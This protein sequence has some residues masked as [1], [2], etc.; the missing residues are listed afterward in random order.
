MPRPMGKLPSCDVGSIAVLLH[1]PFEVPAPRTWPPV[2]PGAFSKLAAIRLVQVLRS[3]IHHDR[4]ADAGNAF[5]GCWR[6]LV[7]L[8]SA[9]MTRGSVGSDYVVGP[10]G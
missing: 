5:I 10:C 9:S 8:R 1:R 3:F 4:P 2:L 7:V 6:T